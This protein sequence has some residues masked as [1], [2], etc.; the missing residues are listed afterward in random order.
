MDRLRAETLA[1]LAE[2]KRQKEILSQEYSAAHALYDRLRNE[3]AL[4]EENVEDISVGLYKP[5]YD[6]DSSAD[7]RT[8][9]EEIRDRQKAL[10]K[11]GQAAMCGQTW[12][13]QGDARAGERMTKQY[14]KLILRAFNGECDRSVSTTLRQFAFAF[15]VEPPSRRERRDRRKARN[16]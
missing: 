6:F 11:S 13:I 14:L 7:Y 8:A 4:V 16:C 10:V 15:S 1:A 9:L 2:Q 5:H 3:I 12:Q